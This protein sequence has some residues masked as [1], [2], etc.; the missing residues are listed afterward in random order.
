MKKI[1]VMKIFNQNKNILNVIKL[2]NHNLRVIPNLLFLINQ[3]LKQVR[4]KV[5]N[6]PNSIK[7]TKYM[8]VNF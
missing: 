5:L 4:I 6:L 7:V 3:C 2:S 8:M 1:V